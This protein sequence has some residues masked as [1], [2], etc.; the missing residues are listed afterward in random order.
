MKGSVLR[1]QI[2]AIQFILLRSSKLLTG[3]HTH[4][5][6]DMNQELLFPELP[7]FHIEDFLDTTTSDRTYH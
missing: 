7:L 3:I 4:I 1:I 6:T 5:I 2:V